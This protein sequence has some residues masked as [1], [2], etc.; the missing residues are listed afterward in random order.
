MD[1]AYRV[2]FHFVLG[3]DSLLR[4]TSSSAI[5]T[6]PL[7]TSDFNKLCFQVRSGTFLNLSFFYANMRLSASI[8]LQC[9][10]AIIRFL[11]DVHITR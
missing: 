6:A 4:Q 9:K 10:D 11:F 8:P 3:P 7:I 2:H 5:A 1:T